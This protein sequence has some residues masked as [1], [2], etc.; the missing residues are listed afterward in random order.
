MLDSQLQARGIRDP[1]VLAAMNAVPRHRFVPPEL[2]PEAYD[3]RPLPIGFGQTISQP[4]IVAFM[5]EALGLV[6]GERVLEVGTGCGYQAA[7]LAEIVDDVFTIEIIPELA[8]TAARRLRE[9]HYRNVHVRSGDGGHGWPEAAPFDAILVAA[10]PKDVPGALVEQ[11]R[12][13]GRMV[14]PLGGESQ[15]L[16]LVEKDASGV[17]QRALLPVRFVPMTGTGDTG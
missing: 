9:L 12:V 10:A 17:R 8:E 15:E 4:F 14:L 2:V 1:L 11:L 7:V 5:T 13:G 6:G 3:D 16:I